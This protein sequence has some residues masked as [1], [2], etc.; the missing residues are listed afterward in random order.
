MSRLARYIRREKRAEGTAMTSRVDDSFGSV[1]RRR[2]KLLLCEFPFGLKPEVHLRAVSL[3]VLLPELISSL[4]DIVFHIAHGLLRS[5]GLLNR[6]PAS[7][8]Q[9]EEFLDGGS[10]S[11]LVGD[12][13]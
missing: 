7:R 11:P 8:T 13:S 12:P 2:R 10:I 9:F 3:T 5:Q 4:S 6:G 1:L